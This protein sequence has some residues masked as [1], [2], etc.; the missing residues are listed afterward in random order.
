[1]L[2]GIAQMDN[3]IRA[4]RAK[5]GMMAAVAAGRFVWPAPIGYVTGSEGGPSLVLHSPSIVEAGRDA[6]KLVVSGMSPCELTAISLSVRSR[7]DTPFGYLRRAL[8][9]SVTNR[10]RLAR[11]SSTG[12]FPTTCST[13]RSRD[14]S[15][16]SGNRNAA[17]SARPSRCDRR[18]QHRSKAAGSTGNTLGEIELGHTKTTAEVHFAQRNE[19]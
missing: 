16:A 13:A 9:N 15:S 8:L 1:V 4:E 18:R 12:F 3:E 11:S 7:V 14:R 17:L 6:W 5:R 2:A 10:N 19:P